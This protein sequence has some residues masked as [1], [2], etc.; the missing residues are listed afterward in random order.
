MQ[1]SHAACHVCE[2]ISARRVP[3]ICGVRQSTHTPRIENNRHKSGHLRLGVFVLA[4]QVAFHAGAQ[5][6][7]ANRRDELPEV[8]LFRKLAAF[9][10]AAGAALLFTCAQAP[11]Q[12]L[13]HVRASSVAFYY[14]RF[15]LEADGDVRVTTSDGMVMRGD[16]F[17][18]DL[19][20]NRFVLAGHVHV[21][22]PSGSQD[23]AALADFL[24]FDRIYFVPITGVPDRWTF[25]NGDFAHPAKG[26]EMPG[27]TFELPDLGSAKPFLVSTSAV[28]AAR[29]YV[30][31]PANRTDISNGLG[32]DAPLPTYYVNF[33]ADRHL[34][35][36]SLSGATFDA[37][38]QA[39][40]N[41]NYIS[42]LHARYDPQNKTYLAFEQHVSSPKAYAVFSVNPA[43]RPSKFWNLILSDQPSE[44][45]QIRT[46]TQLHT[47]QY[48]LSQP[49]ESSQFTNVQITRGGLRSSVQLSGT[50]DNQSLLAAPNGNPD[51]ALYATLGV[52]S[53]ELNRYKPV[54]FT[55]RYGLGYAHDGYKPLQTLGGT[56]YATQ[57]FHY[58]GLTAYTPAMDL[59][60]HS[61]ATQTVK[62]LYL[63]ASVDKQ[64]TWFSAPHFIDGTTTRASVSRI[65]DGIK[66][67]VT[68]YLEYSVQN[69]GD[70]YG[71]QQ[72]AA[73]PVITSQN[74]VSNPGYA[75]FWGFAT[76]R[77]LSLGTV[78]ANG[79]DFSFSLV[80]R[81]HD[82]FPKPV[83]GFFTLPQTDVF[84]RY[85]YSQYFGQPPYDLTPEIRFRVNPHMAIDVARTYY[86]HFGGLNWSPDFVIQVTQ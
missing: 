41:A 5:V 76:F 61:S 8:P 62:D 10:A 3:V 16:A 12:T 69:V 42:A 75:A 40:G 54:R 9:G 52:S 77:T 27:D 74:G 53:F 72:R 18:M 11:A 29:N 33:S 37:T 4:E 36:N 59:S 46:F 63:N 20:L 64:R 78:W 81:K 25:V 34:A 15:L 1:A 23:G 67:R 79:P 48:G 51:H 32:L 56:A 70:D 43:T 39:A 19:K 85:V 28:I 13:V 47:Y 73:Y 60:H 86:F 21:S 14:D 6:G 49:L 44:N 24:D 83:P 2:G 84:G 26:R 50:F 45:L 80:A 66:Q 30:R 17:S 71:A 35:E 22:G 68:S 57:W 38:Y 65:M 58:L 82:D 55:Y 31:F 7:D